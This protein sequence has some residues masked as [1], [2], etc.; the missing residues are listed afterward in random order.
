MFPISRFNDKEKSRFHQFQTKYSIY[1][2]IHI[3][4]ELWPNT[5]KSR[6]NYMYQ[7]L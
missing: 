1:V 5:F 4:I 6:G 2:Y 7:L 3:S